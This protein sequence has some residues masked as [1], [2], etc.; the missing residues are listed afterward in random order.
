VEFDERLY[1]RVIAGELIIQEIAGLPGVDQRSIA[2]TYMSFERLVLDSDAELYDVGTRG[3]RLYRLPLPRRLRID[4]VQGYGA[5]DYFIHMRDASHPERE[6]IEWV[7]PKL[8]RQRNAE[9]CQAH[10][11]GI[12]LADWLSIE[13]E[14]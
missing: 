6:F 12:S 7:D 4:R 3:T 9:L 13:L 8:G 5:Y 1:K 11:F 10:A 2:L 14:G